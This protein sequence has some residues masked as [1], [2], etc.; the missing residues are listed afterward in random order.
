M[1]QTQ[2]EQKERKGKERK[3]NQEHSQGVYSMGN[4][5]AHFFVRDIFGKSSYCD[6]TFF[7]FVCFFWFLS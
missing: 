7:C 1:M 6:L 2:N 4:T 5:R 3:A